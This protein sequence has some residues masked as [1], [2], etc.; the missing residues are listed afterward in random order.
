MKIIKKLFFTITI[1]SS[2]SGPLLAQDVVQQAKAKFAAGSTQEA[3]TLLDSEIAQNPSNASAKRVL[4]DICTDTG[5]KEYSNKNYKNAFEYFKKAVKVMPT[6]PIAS[7]RYW[8]M[9]QDFDV[10]SLKNEGGA[11]SD[12]AKKEEKK[13]DKAVKESGEIIEEA[14]PV[15]TKT[16]RGTKEKIAD[17]GKSEEYYNKKMLQM[18]ERFNKRMLDM[19]TDKKSAGSDDVLRSRDG[20]GNLFVSGNSVRTGFIAAAIFILGLAA[21]FVFKKINAARRGRN[22]YLANFGMD[23]ASKNYNELIKYQNIQEIVAKI[24]SGELDWY[25]IKKSMSE[26]S[27]EIRLEVLNIIEAKLERE[28]MPLNQG[29]AEVLMCLVMDGD[30]YIRRRSKML[31]QGHYAGA[32]A[33]SYAAIAY[34]PEASP[35]DQNV[36][37]IEYSEDSNGSFAIDDLSIVT[38]LAKIVDRKVFK[39]NHSLRVGM[40]CYH[41]A[42]ILGLSAEEKHL[43]YIAGLLH[44]IGY[45]DIPSEIFN[46]RGALT[47]EEIEQIQIHPKRGLELIDFTEVPQIVHDGI[48]SHHERWKGD[49]Y[50]NG[51]AREKIPLI[52]RV[53]AIFDVYE[54][55]I[56]PRPQRPPFSQKE[57]MKIIKKG[58]GHLFDPELIPIFERMAKENL[59]SKEEAWKNK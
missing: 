44:D 1:L 10:S 57:A 51:L 43:F 22:D 20:M 48:L 42:G 25:S 47:D 28:R 5:E 2:L 24:K 4:A 8:K 41:L 32:G 55:L 38:P 29:Q 27:R 37:Q 58:T 16:A 34:S 9:K 14:V 30:D 54:A 33:Q 52:A 45:L 17:T 7:E 15:K 6:H 13:S 56:L 31:I 36:Q 39:D 53:I 26:L 12:T 19:M 49:G 11:I 50:P 40:D 59:L 21:Y 35:A 18:E 23:G 46:K 3:I